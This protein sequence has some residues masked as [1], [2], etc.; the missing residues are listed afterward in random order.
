MKVP[1][2][3]L[4]AFLLL[5][6]GCTAGKSVL[7]SKTAGFPS[8][9]AALSAIDQ[10][11]GT[12]TIYQVT[13]KISL[14]SP[15]GK[16]G[17]RLAVIMQFPDKLRIESIPILGPPDF[18]FAAKDGRFK[19]YLPGNQ[20]FITGN[21]TPDNLSRFLPLSW[22]PERWVSVL[23]GSNTETSRHNEN[24]R[25]TMER[26]LYRVDVLSGDFT[27]ESLW[28]NP[29]SKRLERSEYL[30]PGGL[31]DTILFSSFRKTNGRDFPQ[32]VAIATGEGTTIRIHYESFEVKEEGGNDF[33]E[34]EP[35]PEVRIRTLPD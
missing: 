27:E 14:T 30:N 25:G 12:N 2:T 4:L 26:N 32:N 22:T 15:Q 10:V 19:V 21:A 29:E 1:F 17:F 34:L 33:F 11:G 23:L 24:I 8:P 28:I 35:P 13:A 7:P 3:L 5:F 18:F 16:L 31:K 6:G 20:E 9:Q